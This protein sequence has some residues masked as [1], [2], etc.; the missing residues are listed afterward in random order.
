MSREKQKSS[1]ELLRPHR[2]NICTIAKNPCKQLL[3][4]TQDKPLAAMIKHR[5]AEVAQ[6]NFRNLKR[7]T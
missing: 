4:R 3:E 1:L 6:H 5:N 7:H 2:D